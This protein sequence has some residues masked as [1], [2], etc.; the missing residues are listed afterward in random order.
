MA[1]ETGIPYQNLINLY[2]CVIAFN[3]TGSLLLYGRN[4]VP[5]IEH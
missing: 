2:F 1:D 3:P 4:K 5:N